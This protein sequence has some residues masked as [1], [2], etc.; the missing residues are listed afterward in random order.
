[1]V[2]LNVVAM[3]LS[4]LADRISRGRRLGRRPWLADRLG[5][6]GSHHF[7]PGRVF[8]WKRAFRPGEAAL[9]PWR[10]DWLYALSCRLFLEN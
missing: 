8:L 2:D 5:S 3:K 10:A 9:L 4:E 6:D 7:A 1:M